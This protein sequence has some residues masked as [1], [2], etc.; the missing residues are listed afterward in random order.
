M[1]MISSEKVPRE[2][3]SRVHPGGS[4]PQ[5]VER[6]WPAVPPTSLDHLIGFGDELG[7]SIFRTPN[8]KVN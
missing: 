7:T 2:M 1:K 5:R 4:H 3:G 6:A 8:P